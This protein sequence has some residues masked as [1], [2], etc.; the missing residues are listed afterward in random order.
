MQLKP[1]FIEEKPTV[2]YHGIQITFVR[3]T[4]PQ[5]IWTILANTI[6]MDHHYNCIQGLLQLYWPNTMVL[7]DTDSQILP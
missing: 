4:P 3:V 1:H 7:M 2:E 5:E 6:V